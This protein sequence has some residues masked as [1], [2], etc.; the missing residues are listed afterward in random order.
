MPEKRVRVWVQEFKDRPNLVLQWYDPVTGD[1]KSK[2][3]ET[4]DPREAEHKRADLEADLNA[5]RYQASS[6]M[7]WDRF[8]E[9]F[10]TEYVS[11]MR[12]NTRK[13][14]QVTLDHFERL[15]HPRRV[16][17]ITARTLSSFA[18][19]LRSVK[20]RTGKV[21]MV[22]GTIKMRLQYLRIA[23]KWAEHQEIIG[24][25]PKFPKVKVPDKKPQPVPGESVEKLLAKA[26]DD[27][28]MR[29]F[30]LTGWLG[31][32][33]LAEAFHLEREP[34]EEYPWVDW[35]RDRIIFPAAFV[36]AV[37]DQ[38]V[39]LDPQ[40]RE[41]LGRLPRQGKRLFRFT[42]RRGRPITLSRVGHKVAELARRA[43]VK[44]TMHTLR[45]GFGCRYAGKVPAQV[46]QGLMRHANIQTTTRYYTNVEDAVMEAVLGSSRND[47]RNRAPAGGEAR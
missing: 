15:C 8:R 46:L 9:A 37:R 3:A 23:L 31:G 16:D 21:G 44:L 6:R 19:K 40:L 27:L 10:E 24:K 13:N 47:S 20:L 32:L 2:S 5:G 29:A 38:F 14:H 12:K 18:S 43:G 33:R 28:Q 34:S 11:G 1:R 17:A 39:P 42:T 36:K 26:G 7:A 25:C 30:L 41:A 22:P 4:A 35:G 45:K